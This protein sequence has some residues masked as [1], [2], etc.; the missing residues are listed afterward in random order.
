MVAPIH[1][2]R[3]VHVQSRRVVIYP[4]YNIWFNILR[5]YRPLF[6]LILPIVL[7]QME[8]SKVFSFGVNDKSQMTM[9][10]V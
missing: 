6:R 1:L 5:T 2:S 10:S 9:D 7:G 8:V 4:L 3:D